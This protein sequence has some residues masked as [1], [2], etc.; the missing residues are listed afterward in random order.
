[1]VISLPDSWADVV[2]P[3][4]QSL[5]VLV[6]PAGQLSADGQLR[7][8]IAERR[9]R[10]GGTGPIWYLRLALV[11]A[12]GLGQGEEAV[13]TTSP[14]V[15]TWLQLRFGGRTASVVISPDWLGAEAQA[16]PP[17][18]ERVALMVEAAV[19]GAGA[20]ERA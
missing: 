10:K 6:A 13:V 19:S 18:P 20:G 16:L 4:A 15:L 1:M 9:E 17:A 11:D 7:E 12:L 14:A 5:G 2:E 3:R 8:L